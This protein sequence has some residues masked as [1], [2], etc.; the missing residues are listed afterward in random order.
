MGRR[1]GRTP[2]ANIKMVL[3]PEEKS[4]FFDA[5]AANG[6]EASIAI[7]RYMAQYVEWTRSRPASEAGSPPNFVQRQQWDHRM[8]SQS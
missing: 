2:T 7:R 3:T 8:A 5:C 4:N 6:E 1:P